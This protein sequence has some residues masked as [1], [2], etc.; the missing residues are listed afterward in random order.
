MTV[1]RRRIPGLNS[2]QVIHAMGIDDAYRVERV[3][4]HGRSGVTELV[5]IEGAGPFVRKKIDKAGVDRVVWAT[6]AE[7]DCARLPQVVATYEMPDCFVAVYDYIPGESLADALGRCGSFEIRDAVGIARDVCEATIAMHGLGVMH[8]DITPGNIV[9]AADGAH[10]IDFGNAHMIDS[11]A[12]QRG[13]GERPLGTWGFAAPEQFFSKADARSDIYAIG[14]LLS[15]MLTGALP[16]EGSAEAYEQELPCNESLPAALMALLERAIAFEPS[17]R[18]QTVGELLDDLEA[19]GRGDGEKGRPG[20]HG[21]ASASVLSACRDVASFE[22]SVSTADISP[23]VSAPEPL[24]SDAAELTKEEST[25][26]RR[27]SMTFAVGVASMTFV[28]VVAVMIITIRMFSDAADS[29]DQGRPLSSDH[30]ANVGSSFSDANGELDLDTSDTGLAADVTGDSSADL[31]RAQG[32]LEVVESGWSASDGGY[33]N[34]ALTFSNA[35]SDLTIE[36]PEIL[37]TGRDED[38][39]I[40]FAD[41]QMLNVIFPGESLTC[42]GIA[43]NGAKP[44]TVEFSFGALQEHFVHRE[45]G[46]ASIFEVRGLKEGRSAHGATSFT[47]EVTLAERGDEP[48]PIGQVRLTLVLRDAKGEIVFGDMGFVTCPAEGKTVPFELTPYGC[49]EYA[50]AEVVAIAW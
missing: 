36:F 46:H 14:R 40:V 47:G 42:G 9:V 48:L 43:G 1:Y 21:P 27:R 37:I 10:L 34:Y 22:A 25:L 8:L 12:I 20:P 2:E 15:V 3:L 4:A 49:P 7:A 5:T 17:A 29:S 13:S 32:G 28:V 6:L 16:Q 23:S 38:G 19:F 44:A 31:S 41:S 50:S 18:Y 35:S 26:R 39:N 45:D 30:V 11:V 33:V 24:A